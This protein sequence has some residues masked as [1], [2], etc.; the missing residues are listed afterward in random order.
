MK[1]LI[2]VILFVLTLSGLSYAQDLNYRL[3]IK[4]KCSNTIV[5]DIFYTLQKGGS[6][7]IPDTNGVTR[8]PEAGAYILR[9]ASFSDVIELNFQDYKSYCDTLNAD[10]I[11]ECLEPTTRPRFIGFCCCDFTPCEGYKIDRFN[12]GQVRIESQFRNGI[13]I[14]KFKRYNQSGKLVEVTTYSKKGKRGKR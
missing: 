1:Q 11:I 2:T 8:L 5:K 4:N 13:P 6:N 12:N 14:G 7:Y 10:E 9:S 3:C